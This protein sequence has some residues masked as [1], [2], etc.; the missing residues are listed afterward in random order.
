MCCLFKLKSLALQIHVDLWISGVRAQKRCHKSFFCFPFLFSFFCP[1]G[2]STEISRFSRQDTNPEL[3]SEVLVGSFGN[4]SCGDPKHV[5][6]HKWRESLATYVHISWTQIGSLGAFGTGHRVKSPSKL[7]GEMNSAHSLLLNFCQPGLGSRNV[8][9]LFYFTPPRLTE[10]RLDT[11]LPTRSY[12]V[13][14]HKGHACSPWTWSAHALERVE[15]GQGFHNDHTSQTNIGR[16]AYRLAKNWNKQKQEI[17][18]APWKPWLPHG[19][20]S[21]QVTPLPVHVLSA[22]FLLFLF[23]HLSAQLFPTC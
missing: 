3:S 12:S 9:F 6:S 20:H 18:T 23:E 22:N 1:A 13:C 16:L 11:T 15:V 21:I 7:V 2:K 10:S 5:S 8:E 17:K 4:P 19:E 14:Q